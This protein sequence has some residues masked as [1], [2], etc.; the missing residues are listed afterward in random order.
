[1]G[2]RRS[3]SCSKIFPVNQVQKFSVFT[4]QAGSKM[5]IH[6]PSRTMRIMLNIGVCI[7][8][9]KKLLY[10]GS[11][12]RKSKRLVPIVARIKITR[13]EKLGDRYLRN[14][15]A[16]AEDAEFSLPGKHF[17]TTQQA[18]LPAFTNQPVIFQYL[19]FG[20]VRMK[21]F[22]GLPDLWL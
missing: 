8:L 10:G 16:I 14:F 22:P 20:K 18:G 13:P 2:C 7:Q 11:T 15:F 19:Y 5:G 9:G 3:Q 1:M 17:F 6:I 21:C 12:E 4:D